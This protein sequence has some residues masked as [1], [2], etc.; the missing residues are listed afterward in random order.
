MTKD[1]VYKGEREVKTFV[2]LFHGSDVLLKKSNLDKK[3]SYFTT[4]GSLLLTSFT[5]E[6]FLNDLGDKIIKYW[7]EIERITIL[8]KY[9]VLCKELGLEPDFSKRPYQTL[10]RVFKFRNSIAHGR[11][12][13]LKVSKDISSREE[14]W[15]HEPKT[16]WEE[17]CTEINAAICREDIKKIIIE[18]NEAATLGEYP[19]ISG[20]T[21]SSITKK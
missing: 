20:M 2:D 15:D 16:D 5:L 17:F 3:G 9:S 4:M 12:I 18:L 14:P 21:I 19:F 7:T 10:K 1:A 11:S 8:D 13:V 6:A